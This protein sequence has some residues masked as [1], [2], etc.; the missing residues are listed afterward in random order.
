MGFTEDPPP[1]PANM[2]GAGRTAPRQEDAAE[3]F[4][5]LL[6]Q[7]NEECNRAASHGL[8]PGAR[9]ASGKTQ[10]G[11]GTGG[12]RWAKDGE[13]RGR[14]VRGGNTAHGYD[15]RYRRGTG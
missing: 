9:S 11:G 12:V 8:S 13:Q 1:P 2:S 14:S 7:L 4:T 10:S 6:D 5:F 3:F 15:V